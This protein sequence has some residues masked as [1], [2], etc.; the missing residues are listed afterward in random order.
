MYLIFIL[1]NSLFV[2]TEVSRS[3]PEKGDNIEFYIEFDGYDLPTLVDEYF[4]ARLAR[5]RA[6]S[7]PNRVIIYDDVKEL[8][9]ITKVAFR[10]LIYKRT[11]NRPKYLAPTQ[12][13]LFMIHYVNNKENLVYVNKLIDL[14]WHIKYDE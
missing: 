5:I 10:D 11:A 14:H 4:A 9:H 2:K 1:K 6:D 7:D 13:G 12:I 3:K 8:C